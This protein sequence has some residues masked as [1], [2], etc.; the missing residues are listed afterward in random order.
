[1]PNQ[2]HYT[3]SYKTKPNKTKI[4]DI[5]TWRHAQIHRQ[6][7]CASPG[8]STLV[9]AWIG[10]FS[11]LHVETNNTLKTSSAAQGVVLSSTHG[12]R[13]LLQLLIKASLH[14]RHWLHRQQL[15]PRMQATHMTQVAQPSPFKDNVRSTISLCYMLYVETRLRKPITLL[16][17]SKRTPAR[18]PNTRSEG[19]DLSGSVRNQPSCMR[20]RHCGKFQSYSS[21]PRINAPRQQRCKQ[22]YQQDHAHKLSSAS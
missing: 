2:L 17:G 21:L 3:K 16:A 10:E 13:P 22:L 19:S 1:M 8:G 11:S 15:S 5:R 6:D 12:N 9:P 14:P 7:L 20:R 18:S 4:D